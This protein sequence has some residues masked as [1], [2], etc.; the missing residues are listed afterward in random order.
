[1]TIKIVVYYNILWAYPKTRIFH[2]FSVFGY[3]LIPLKTVGLVFWVQPFLNY[4]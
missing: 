1:M 4:G 3:A 2:R